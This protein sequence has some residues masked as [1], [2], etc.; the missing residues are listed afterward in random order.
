MSRNYIYIY[1]YISTGTIYPFWIGLFDKTWLSEG[2]VFVN[3]YGLDPASILFSSYANK[4]CARVKFNLDLGAPIIKSGLC[5][6]EKR[7]L[8]ELSIP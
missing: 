7:F 2:G 1:K 5:T 8:C 3:V 4:K 6:K